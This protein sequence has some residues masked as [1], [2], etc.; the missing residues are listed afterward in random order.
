VLKI[1]RSFVSGVDRNVDDRAQ[2]I[3]GVRRSSGQLLGDA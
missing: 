3:T 1:D 2:A